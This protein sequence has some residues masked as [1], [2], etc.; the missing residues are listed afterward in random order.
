MNNS[1]PENFASELNPA[2]RDV[3]FFNNGPLLVIAGAG[4]GKTKT[5][6]YRVARLISEGV[7]AHAI[8]LLTFTRKSAQEMLQR[9]SQLLDSRC[10]NV[11]GGTFHAFGNIMLR[12][13]AHHIGYSPQFTILDRSDSEDLI[14]QIRKSKPEIKGDKR[15]PKKGTIASIIGKAIN[16]DK[17]LSTIISNEYPQ[18]LEFIDTINNISREYE[19]QKQEMK[20]MDYDD[21]LTKFSTLLRTN[22]EVRAELQSQFKYIMVDEYQDT[23]HSQSEIITHLTNS[24]QNIMVVGDDSQ[25]IYSFRG[26]NFKN[27]MSF[28]TLFPSAQVIKL[29]QNYRSSQPILDLTNAV[30][31]QAKEKY[32]KTLFTENKSTSKPTY[33]ETNSENAQSKFICKK[34]LELREND[35]PLNRIAVLMRSGWHSNDLEVELKASNL[36]FV[37]QG[38]FKFVEASHVKDVIAY[39]RIIYNPLDLLAW[40][41]V[42]NFFDGLGPKSI[43]T[44]IKHILKHKSALPWVPLDAY[45]KKKYYQELNG[46]LQLLFNQ[47]QPLP[48]PEVLLNKILTY[49]KPFF[50]LTYDNYNKRQTD[51]DSLESIVSK[52]NDLETLLTEMSLDPPTESQV[53]AVESSKD[54]ENLVLSTIHSAKGLEWHTVFLISA[55]DGYLPSFQSLGDLGQLEEE[56]RLMYVALTR[57]EKDLYIL[58]PNLDMSKGNYYRFSG[59]QFSQPSRFLEEAQ[60]LAQFTESDY[61]EE[62]KPD[63]ANSYFQNKKTS[64]TS[65]Y[66]QNKKPKSN[67]ADSYFE[68]PDNDTSQQ[69]NTPP[70]FYL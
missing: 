14:S 36:P 25:S 30:I 4:S 8:L 27:I 65:N 5:V 61:Y 15:F 13:Y 33:I 26:A 24:D 69:F 28:P 59:M 47:P 22:P 9:A 41:R 2:Q 23:N 53:D 68:E 46:L 48:K 56:R 12:K 45:K 39:L 16:A 67:F 29:E 10:N 32:S 6:T 55:V 54:E 58:K 35:V 49:Y 57:A 70:Q 50:K 43:T 31:N 62:K 38:G 60:I 21:L 52:Y 34:I 19:E 1:L 3:V 64:N 42:L 66:S 7:P 40:N 63:F 20:V 17:T 51:L 37:K 18:F 44:L 11:A